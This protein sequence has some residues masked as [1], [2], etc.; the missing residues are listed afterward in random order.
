[1][2]WQTLNHLSVCPVLATGILCLACAHTAHSWSRYVQ[3]VCKVFY[4]NL[5]LMMNLPAKFVT[6]TF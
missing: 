3:V 2:L 1:M 5:T 4:V 6:T